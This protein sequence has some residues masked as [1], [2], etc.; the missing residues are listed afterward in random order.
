MN[1][2]PSDLELVFFWSG[3]VYMSYAFTK[4]FHHAMSFL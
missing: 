4:A 3:L 2:D 1:Q